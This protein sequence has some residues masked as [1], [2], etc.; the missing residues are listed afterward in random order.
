[1][2]N[3]VEKSLHIGIL[4][5]WIQGIPGGEIKFFFIESRRAHVLP[6]LEKFG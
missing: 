5:G 6:L 1:M 2:R 4:L 3:T